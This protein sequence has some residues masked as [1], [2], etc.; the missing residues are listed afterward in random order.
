MDAAFHLHVD[1][2]VSALER[3]PGGVAD[4]M[5]LDPGVPGRRHKIGAKKRPNDTTVAGFPAERWPSLLYEV[6]RVLAPG[7]VCWWVCE[8]SQAFL[9]AR[10]A[11]R[12][13]FSIGTP[14]VW[15][16]GEQQAV[17]LGFILP[18]TRG[19][20]RSPG[21]ELVAIPRPS[22]EGVWPGELPEALCQGL[23]EAASEPGE[24]IVD[25]FCGSGAVGVAAILMGRRYLGSDR[26]EL[27][28]L[29]ARTRLGHAG[30]R[31][32]ER[33]ELLA[34]AHVPEGGD[35]DLVIA[36]PETE[37]AGPERVRQLTMFYDAQRPG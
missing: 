22:A 10:A 15:D 25:P 4:L 8:S 31:E 21:A 32:L 19:R 37:R 34:T 14:M 30:G 20:P 26:C 33:P 7:R 6:M 29:A 17:R 3:L 9:A 35:A 12:M 18:L 27:A 23:I 24:L 2:A 11:E 1:D 16:R 28:V 5:V 36:E 13:G